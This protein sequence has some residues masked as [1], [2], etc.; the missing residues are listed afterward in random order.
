MNTERLSQQTGSPKRNSNNKTP[1]NAPLRPSHKVEKRLD[2]TV[3][4]HELK[5]RSPPPITDSDEELPFKPLIRKHEQSDS[6]NP[7]ELN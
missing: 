6:K 3:K 5:R 4:N 2:I 7:N 1:P